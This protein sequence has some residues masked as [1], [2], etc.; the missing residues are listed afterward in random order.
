MVFMQ[1]DVF[2]KTCKNREYIS[3]GSNCSSASILQSKNLRTQAYPFDWNCT[4]LNSAF[5]LLLN[6]FEGFMD[7]IQV[8]ETL[9]NQTY[10]SFVV[11]LE[12]TYNILLPHHISGDEYKAEPIKTLD[13]VRK[14]YK[15]R[16][17]RIYNTLESKKDIVFFFSTGLNNNQSN[18]YRTY[19]A[20]VLTF[21]SK[22]FFFSV[23]KH[24]D[25]SVSA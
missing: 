1:T 19:K 2:M 11:A 7:D 18:W 21:G 3:I 23:R 16:I 20:C 13:R 4:P 14:M 5:T 12:S 24:N 6:N 15:R 10:P 17:N 8:D 22:C 9:V 25:I